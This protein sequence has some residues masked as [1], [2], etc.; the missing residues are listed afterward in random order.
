MDPLET[1]MRPLVSA[2][3]RNIGEI[4]RARELREQL[5]GSVIAIRVRDTALSAI[6][7]IREDGIALS[8]D[9][10]LEPHVIISGTLISLARL[11]A[12]GDENSIRSG[13]VELSGDVEKAQAFQD[14]LASARPDIEEELSRVV[15]DVAAHGLGEFA[16]GVGQWARDARTTMGSN[17]REYLQE[18]SGDV[19][20][21]DEVNEF[22]AQVN[23]L[24][25]DV[26]RLAAR[27][28]RLA[29]RL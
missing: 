5:D 2:L 1:L 9:S 7:D 12:S 27:I 24:R 26:E 4:T 10:D 6:F 28:E 17:L 15:G 3:N 29:E 13:Q 11:A 16:R 19:P 23:T 14:L 25:D 21:Q 22:Q 8:G 20:S 18:E